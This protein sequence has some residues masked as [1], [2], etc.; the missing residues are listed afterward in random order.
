MQIV[1]TFACPPVDGD[2]DHVKS[3]KNLVEI[4]HSSHASDR[5]ALVN[6]K[7]DDEDDDDDD[8]Q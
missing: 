4:T 3:Y 1:F 7:H 2:D 8:Y 6:M 5:K